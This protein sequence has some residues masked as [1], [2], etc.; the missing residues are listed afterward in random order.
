MSVSRPSSSSSLQV[1]PLSN[2]GVDFVEPLVIL[3]GTALYIAMANICYTLG[4]VV[5]TTLYDGRPR[6]RLYKSGLVFA[7]I[8]TA[9][10]GVWAV[11]AW[12]ITIHT[13]QKLD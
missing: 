7:A 13:G 12:V 1:L 8:L 5:D 4:W 2:R 3:P 9:L 10:P 6:T 11:I